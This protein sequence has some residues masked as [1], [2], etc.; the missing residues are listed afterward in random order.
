MT[1]RELLQAKMIYL[2]ADIDTEKLEYLVL[3]ATAAAANTKVKHTTGFD[4]WKLEKLASCRSHYFRADHSQIELI[5]NKIIEIAPLRSL[6][7]K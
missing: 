7:K 1:K 4:D 2:C 3:M 5:C 6:P